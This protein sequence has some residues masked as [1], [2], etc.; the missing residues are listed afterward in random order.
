MLNVIVAMLR[1]SCDVLL[2]KQAVISAN[3]YTRN[4]MH[5]V[6]MVV[7]MSEQSV[8]NCRINSSYRRCELSLFLVGGGGKTGRGTSSVK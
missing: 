5:T 8:T 1:Y 3:G 4:T 2:C 7:T 6:E